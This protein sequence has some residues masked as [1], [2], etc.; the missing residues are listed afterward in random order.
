MKP[1]VEVGTFD[2]LSIVIWSRS[3]VIFP[4]S[5]KANRVIYVIEEMFIEPADFNALDIVSL[6]TL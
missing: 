3:C 5:A 4:F 1:L 6:S 2:K